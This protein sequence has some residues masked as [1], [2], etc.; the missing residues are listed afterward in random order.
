MAFW[1]EYRDL[2]VAALATSPGVETIEDVER[3]LATGAY[4]AF[5]GQRSIAITEISHFDR[6]TAVTVIHGGGELG[7]LLDVLEP[8]IEAYA[9]AIEADQVMGQ[10]RWGW[11][12]PCE[13]KGYRLGWIVM[14][15]DLAAP[16]NAAA[17]NFGLPLG[18]RL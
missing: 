18:R 3:R 8:M 15:K 16:G 14:V 1:P 7:E 10:G 2:I 11:R 4:Q 12:R 13:A 5:Y 9:R 17:P 6:A